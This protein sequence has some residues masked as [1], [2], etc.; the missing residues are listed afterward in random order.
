[1]CSPK[2]RGASLRAMAAE[3]ST[4]SETAEGSSLVVERSQQDFDVPKKLRAKVVH[5]F[6]RGSKT[7]GFPTAN[8]EVKWDKGE[9]PEDLKPEEREI[10]EFA[11]TCKAGIYYAWAQVADGP[12]RGVYKTAMSV[13]WNPTF[14]DV[15]VKT[16]EPWILH[17]YGADFYDCELRL[18]V[19]GYVRDELKF[20]K[21]DEL[22]Q[23]RSG[24]TEN[25][26]AGRWRHPR[27]RLWR[28][29][30]SSQEQRRRKGRQAGPAPCSEVGPGATETV[31]KH[32][33]L[34][35]RADIFGSAR[36]ARQGAAPEAPPARPGANSRNLRGP[37]NFCLRRCIF[38]KLPGTTRCPSRWES[39]ATQ[40]GRSR[41]GALQIRK[42]REF[43][44]R[45]P[46]ASD[47]W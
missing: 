21:F 14:T 45:G 25:S 11:R 29:T 36:G 46:P 24:R 7:L 19:C 1:T 5:G 9:T 18:V 15:K 34:E 44:R 43:G 17:D 28:V 33:M 27:P 30:R 47:P 8:M 38:F 22:I 37:P 42:G 39:A 20:E 32:N 10:L 35:V 31:H 2:D 16:I 3:G 12:D 40:P 4:A 41:R 26:A 6:G 23:L 13:G